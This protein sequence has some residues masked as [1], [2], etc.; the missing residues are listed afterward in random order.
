[1]NTAST[2]LARVHRL[3]SALAAFTIVLA[4]LLATP[5][6]ASWGAESLADGSGKLLIEVNKGNL[7]RLSRPATTVF[8]ANPEIA[9]IDVKSPTLVYVFGRAPGETTL[10]AV[11]ADENIVLDQSVVVTLNLTRLN[12]FLQDVAPGSTILARS[13]AGGIVLTGGVADVVSAANAERLARQFVPE[14]ALIINQIQINGPNQV[15]LRVRVA[16][17]SRSTLKRFGLNIDFLQTAGD[18]VFGIASGNLAGTGGNTF[19]T[20]NNGSFNGFGG[21][22]GNTG[23]LNLLIDA[24]ET[25]GLISILAEPNLTAMSGETASF[26]AGGEF[27]IPVPQKDGNL[28]IEFKKFGV[29]LSFTPTVL[30]GNR[31]SMRVRPEVSSLSSAG[32]VTIQ[33][34][35]IPALSVRRADTSV[36]L[37]SGQSFAIAGLLQST[38]N[39][40]IRKFPGLGDLPIIG[41]LF[42]STEFQ[43]NETE[44]VIIVTPY[45]VRPVSVAL[46]APT[47]GLVQPNDTQRLRDGDIYRQQPAAGRSAPLGGTG[48]RLVG[49]VGFELE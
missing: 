12:G 37:A 29:A 33:Q 34:I 14:E 18:I 48:E 7:I 27:P 30:S 9:D 13:V 47:D 6:A 35:Q 25:E 45:I 24:L 3:V 16:E 40:D 41:V 5:G 15:N 10:F 19:A 17:V 32:A 23:D 31:I 1:M 2:S 38:S 8:V 11:D 4:I 39:N 22:D 49:P 21:V 36:E 26:L 28:T 20:R 44:L 43:R 46:A 42:R